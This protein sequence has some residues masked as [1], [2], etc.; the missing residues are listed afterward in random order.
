MSKDHIST[1]KL[2]LSLPIVLLI[3][4]HYYLLF[5]M[6]MLKIKNSVYR[7]NREIIFFLV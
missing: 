4:M 5:H 2:P 3:D 7:F 1:A 6:F